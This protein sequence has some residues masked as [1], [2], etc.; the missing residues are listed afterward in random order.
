MTLV[1]QHA[2]ACTIEWI[3]LYLSTND[4]ICHLKTYFTKSTSKVAAVH[5][6]RFQIKF[7]AIVCSTAMMLLVSWQLALPIINHIFDHEYPNFRHQWVV[8]AIEKM[9]VPAPCRY[10]LKG[11]N[12]HSH[13]HKSGPSMEGWGLHSILYKTLSQGIGDCSVIILVYW[14]VLGTSK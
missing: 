3:L 6:R 4:K 10:E 9:I 14:V 7:L 12:F 1:I 5:W 11:R 13:W 8:E 2:V